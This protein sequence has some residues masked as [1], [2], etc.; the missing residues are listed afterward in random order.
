MPL[1]AAPG[2]TSRR[3]HTRRARAAVVDEN[4]WAVPH[5]DVRGHMRVGGD[6]TE[7]VGL[8]EP[9]RPRLV[10]PLAEVV[11]AG[12]RVEEF[13]HFPPPGRALKW[14]GGR[15]KPE[16]QNC[17]MACASS[18]TTAKNTDSTTYATFTDVAAGS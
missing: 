5:V 8:E 2:C 7:H 14:Q 18:S 12:L 13:R 6:G 11:E 1:T 10:L 17:G 16:L 9:P 4:R 3:E 15:T